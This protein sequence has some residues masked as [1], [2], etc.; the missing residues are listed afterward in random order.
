M[1]Q[2]H[3]LQHLDIKPRN[4]FLISDRVKVAD[5][6]LVKHLEAQSGVLN[7]VT[8]LYAPP[9]T[10][11]GKISEHSDQYSLA[12]VYQ[13]M[14]TGQRPFMGKNARQLLIQHTQEEPELRNLPESERP[15]IARALAKDPNKRFPNCLSFVRALFNARPA[16]RPEE[17]VPAKGKAAKDGS[18]PRTMSETLE[19]MVLEQ[20]TPDEDVD[21]GAEPVRSGDEVA[22]V[23][24]HGLTM[25]N[26]QTGALRPTMIIGIGSFARRAV[27]ELRCRFLDRFGDLGKIPLLR[28]LY[29][30]CD[31]DAVKSAMRG[32]S[33]IACTNEELYHLSLQPIGNYRRRMLEQIS[34]W[35][36]QEKLFSLP[37]SLQTQGGRAIG[38]LAFV[39][40]HMRLL[41]KVR[42]EIQKITHPDCLYQSVSQTG[43]ALRDRRPRIYLIAA[44][45]GGSSGMIVDFGYALRRLMNQLKQPNADITAILFCGAPE[46]PATPKL[47]QANVYATLTEMQHFSDANIPFTAQYGADG[48]RFVEQGQPY[49]A[50]YLLK[51]AHRSPEALRDA[52]AHLGSYLFHELTTPLGIRLENCRKRRPGEE[53]TPFRSFGTYAVWFPR[54]LLLRLAARHTLVGLLKEW[55]ALGELSAQ[56]EVEAACARALADPELRFEALCAR[57][58]SVT[59]GAFDGNLGG[60]LTN[61]LSALEEQS[62]QS[63]AQEDM[64]NWVRQALG[65]MQDW[66]GTHGGGSHHDSD[67]QKSRLSRAL[68]T[69]TQKVAEQW[70]Q[71][72]SECAFSLM[73]HPGRRVATAEAALGRFVQF[74]QEAAAQHHSRLEQQAVKT[75]QVSLLLDKALE[76]CLSGQGGFSFFGGRSRRLLRVFMDY[77]AA[78]SRQCMAEGLVAAGLQFYAVLRG[79]LDDRIREMSFCRQRLRHMQETMEQTQA[80]EEIINARL[81]TEVGTGQSPLPSTES[82]WDAIRDS[83]TARLV[84]PNG[85]VELEKA[86]ERFVKSLTEE[87]SVQLDQ[88]VQDQVLAHMGGLHKVCTTNSDLARALAA[89]VLVQLASS[90][91]NLLPVT[92]V[93]DAEFSSAAAHNIDLAQCVR[94]YY[95]HALPL[96]NTRTAEAQPSF[97]L[98]PASDPG[99]A[100]GEKAKQAVPELDLVLVSGQSDLM[101]CRE[102]GYLA[103]EELR[104]AFHHCRQAYDDLSPVPN[105]SPHARFDITDWMPLDPG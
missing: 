65:R 82:Y 2:K 94:Q 75:R 43:L 59:A 78:Y 35:L 102:Q 25:H 32:S 93:A 76:G 7:S 81:E 80:A 61:L 95:K 23:S 51:L 97:L 101:F 100:F 28:F 16:R 70:D 83:K 31:G 48:P 53:T 72:L 98:I 79:R 18:R 4:L 89:P 42:K 39:D 11:T 84:L 19:D 41:G 3:N 44:A 45:G 69:A 87:Q 88:A 46:D 21:L 22:E 1:I 60:A 54:G 52:V 90:L 49:N 13:E 5:F 104:P 96:L 55:Q 33:E 71:R 9:E 68:I 38:R 64:P 73:E 66:V 63:V 17:L 26:P 47:E 92:D 34:E 99:K 6:G 62:Q 15:I 74:C 36:P 103:F 85:E 8:P 30:D 12:I 58:E 20:M 10:F 57:I 14:L 67:L 40:H 56:T 24:Q 29:V 37:R 86:A 105:S 27:F 77:L 50:A 91:G